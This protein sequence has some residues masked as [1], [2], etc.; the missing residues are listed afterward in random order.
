MHRGSWPCTQVAVH[1]PDGVQWLSSFVVSVRWPRGAAMGHAEVLH[2]DGKSLRF[3]WGCAWDRAGEGPSPRW[4]IGGSGSWVMSGSWDPTVMWYHHH[5]IH[6]YITMVNHI[7]LD[8][9][10]ILVESCAS[11]DKCLSNGE[12]TSDKE[13]LMVHIGPSWMRNHLSMARDANFCIIII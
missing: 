12:V 3:R 1:A 2:D 4:R 6:H 8:V 9:Q 5:G 11:S 13:S 10:R 7:S